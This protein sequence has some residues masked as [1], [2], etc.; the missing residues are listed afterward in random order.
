M[1][2]PWAMH[3]KLIKAAAWKYFVTHKTPVDEADFNKE[4]GVGA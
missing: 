4:C 3:R 2:D 1:I